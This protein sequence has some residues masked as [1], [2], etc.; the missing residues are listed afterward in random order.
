MSSITIEALKEF[1]ENAE[2]PTVSTI[3]VDTLKALIEEQTT[4]KPMPSKKAAEYLGVKLAA[5]YKYTHE[6]LIPFYKPTGR[7]NYFLKS[8]LDAFLLGK[9][10]SSIAEI[11]EQATQIVLK[12]GKK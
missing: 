4:E 7:K 8:D 1:I 3:S 12:G 6:N 5:L 10:S 11:E 2:K 9:R